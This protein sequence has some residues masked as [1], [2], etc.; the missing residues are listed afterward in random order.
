M[1]P[2]PAKSQIFIKDETKNLKNITVEI[3]D[4]V[5]RNLKN[6]RVQNLSSTEI[7]VDV[8][9]LLPQSYIIKVYENKTLI[10]TQKII[11]E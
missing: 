2:N 7:S 5:G 1:Y 10:L 8:D 3:S 9:G 4:A 6:P 11:K